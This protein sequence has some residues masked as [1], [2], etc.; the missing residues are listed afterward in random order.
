MKLLEGM[1]L[2]RRPLTQICLAVVTLALT[3]ICS[4]V[5]V[6]ADEASRSSVLSYSARA[7]VLEFI[8]ELASK[9]QFNSEQLEDWFAK[10]QYQQSIID[11]ISR[12]AEKRLK[13]WEYRRIFLKDARI[14][15]GA[16]FWLANEKTLIKVAKKYK[17]DPEIIVSILGVETLYGQRAGNYRVIDALTTLGF[18]YP[19]RAKFF[20]RQ[21]RQFFLL[22]REEGKNPFSFKGSYA[23]AMGY[24][25]FIPSSYREYAV[26]FDQD[27][28]RD[29]W[30]NVDD[31]VA[32][33]ANY[34]KRHHWRQN[35]PIVHPVKV[36]GNAFEPFVNQGMR[37]KALAKGA[38]ASHFR[39]LGVQTDLPDDRKV[40]LI[41]LEDKD[42]SK[43]WLAEHNFF[44]I[45][46]YNISRLYAMAVFDLGAAIKQAYCAAKA[47]QKQRLKSCQREP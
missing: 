29:I 25:Q 44:V 8:D 15:G 33:V 38:V 30:Q 37:H 43:Y 31:A 7:D 36:S 9:D 10:A 5:L 24:G 23:G 19:P 35:G 26:D 41:R 27:G 16:K 28:V 4:G 2:Q 42:G 14:Q 17:V 12:P 46:T 40:A 1:V 20:R 32:S 21:L 18:D 13:W 34:L 39:T 11:A 22:T 3:V 45:T 47:S 6:A